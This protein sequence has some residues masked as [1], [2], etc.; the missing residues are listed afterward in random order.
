MDSQLQREL[1]LQ[2]RLADDPGALE[3]QLASLR[4]R[5][6]AEEE[7]LFRAHGT[8]R[9]A[10]ELWPRLYDHDEKIRAHF[11]AHPEVR[12]KLK[13]LKQQINALTRQQA[14]LMAARLG[15]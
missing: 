12:E 10:W 14:E 15:R 11:A 7:A 9:A 2:R 6:S 3:T 8:H 13:D 4:K 5:S 1:E